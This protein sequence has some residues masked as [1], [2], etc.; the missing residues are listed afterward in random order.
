[1]VEKLQK[2]NSKKK[3]SSKLMF[4]NSTKIFVKKFPPIWNLLRW[5]KDSLIKLSRLKDVFMM[6]ILFH[7]W[8]EQTYRFS[9]RRLLPA[10]KNRYFK[11]SKPSIPCDLLESKSSKIPLIDEINVVARGSSFDLNNLKNLKGPTFLVAFWLPP[12]IDDRGSI[13]H[14]FVSDVLKKDTVNSDPHN[15]DIAKKLEN[16]KNFQ[17]LEVLRNNNFTY[18]EN[19]KEVLEYMM[20]NGHNVLSV[21]AHRTDEDGNHYPLSNEW[22]EQSYINLCTHIGVAERFYRPPLLAPYSNWTPTG[23]GLI[24]IC[25]LSFFVKKINVYGWDFYLDSSPKNMGYWEL[26]FNM[27]KYKGDLRSRNHFESA[28]L[29]FYYGYQFSKLPNINIHGHL[30]KLDK[31][32]KLMKKIE[33]VLFQ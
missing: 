7:I 11:E 2:E 4:Y 20:E 5:L 33:R 23:F 28:L 27:Y 12:R 3:S 14:C 29:N 6:M 16:E 22:G 31:H 19:H 15:F 13:V 26:F 30:G 17:N 21:L 9:T 1:M 32:E 24:A 25:A 8:P 10:K 18:I